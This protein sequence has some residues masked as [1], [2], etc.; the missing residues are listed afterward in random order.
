MAGSIMIHAP[1]IFIFFPLLFASPLLEGPKLRRTRG[2]CGRQM[3]N[4]KQQL[5]FV[6]NEAFG[7][8]GYGF[9]LPKGVVR[10]RCATPFAE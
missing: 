10:M 5:K 6:H 8:L 3:A 1:Q 7:W 9:G 4:G 2:E